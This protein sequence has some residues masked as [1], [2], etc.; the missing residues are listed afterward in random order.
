MKYYLIG[1]FSAIII[2]AVV[3]ISGI[4]MYLAQPTF[5]D[6][7]ASAVRVDGNQL[8]QHVVVLSE[9]FYP[10]SFAYRQNLINVIDYIKRHFESAG[11]TVSIQEFTAS[12]QDLG[13]V[14]IPRQNYANLSCVFGKGKGRK[15]IIGAHY[16]SFEDT[17]GAD[18]NASGVA[19]LIEL[20]YLFQKNP[21]DREIELVAYSL[22]EPPFF[23]TDE[24]GSY[25]HAKSTAENSVQPVGVIVL[26]MI[27]Y[28]TDEPE[29][30][31]YPAPGLGAIYPQKG[32][33]ITVVGNTDQRDFTRRVKILMK[34][35]TPLPVYSLVGPSSLRGVDFSDH[36]NYWKFGINAVMIT[37]TSFYRNP[38][39]HRPEDTAN[40]LDYDRMSQV[41]VMIFETARN[42]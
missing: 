40:T 31:T 15:V 29:S 28:F 22:E 6:S 33:F 16:D 8:R 4:W 18:D 5:S 21:P 37:D 32:D 34:G 25:V 2:L 24:M 36:R 19:G 35:R 39:Y 3:I 12:E 7:P 9:T 20:A 13:E 23:A 1:C 42:L 27:G 38:N 26:E 11:G 14:I 41:V 10:R 30:Q 17:P